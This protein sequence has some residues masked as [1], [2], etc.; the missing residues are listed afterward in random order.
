M[1]KIFLALIVLFVSCKMVTHK[2]KGVVRIHEVT[3]DKYGTATF[4]TLIECED[5]K[6]RDEKDQ[7]YYIL[8]IGTTCIITYN[9]YVSK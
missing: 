1:K 7:S 5:G 4:H 2:I 6:I 8:P 9:E 3:S